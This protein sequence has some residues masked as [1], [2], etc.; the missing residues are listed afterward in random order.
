M[1]GFLG[2]DI[3][4]R[5]FDAVLL[6]GETKRHKVF[7]NTD[8]GFAALLSWL[9][10]AAGDLHACMEATGGLGDDLALFLHALN[11]PGFAG[12]QTV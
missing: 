4:K 11:R 5:S 10:D 3:A 7:D 6:V 9:G 8:I 12:G 2:I 1:R